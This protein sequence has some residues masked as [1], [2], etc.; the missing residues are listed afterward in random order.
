MRAAAPSHAPALPRQLSVTNTAATGVSRD[1]PSLPA[2]CA[3]VCMTPDEGS[4]ALAGIAAR[5][6]AVPRMYIA[7][8][9]GA[10]NARPSGIERRGCLISPPM[11][12][13]ASGPVHANAITDQKMTSL[14]PNVGMSVVALIGVADP[15]LCQATMP[16]AMSTIVA[17]QRP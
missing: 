13:A 3:I 17:V 7:A 12:D 10:A 8:I 11:N 5:T 4:T 14:K 15:N 2:V 16:M 1:Q 9:A 6:L